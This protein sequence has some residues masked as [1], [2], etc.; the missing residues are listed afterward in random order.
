M[1]RHLKKLKQDSE[2]NI[3]M[4]LEERSAVEKKKRVTSGFILIKNDLKHFLNKIKIIRAES[5][6]IQHS[7]F[8]K[9]IA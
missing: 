8:K 5:H 3:Q 4:L 2:A 6:A 7:S 1:M 9:S